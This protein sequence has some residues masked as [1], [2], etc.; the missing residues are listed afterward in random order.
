MRPAS[1]MPFLLSFALLGLGACSSLSGNTN[2]S[3]AGDFGW[4]VVAYDKS[5]GTDN[6]INYLPPQEYGQKLMTATTDRET[7]VELYKGPPLKFR[8]VEVTGVK[9][10]T[11]VTLQQ[12]GR[13]VGTVPFAEGTTFEIGGSYPPTA[14][15]LVDRSAWTGADPVV[16]YELLPGQGY[17]L[18]ELP[19]IIGGKYAG[20]ENLDCTPPGDI[21]RIMGNRSYTHIRMNAIVARDAGQRPPAPAQ[22]TPTKPAS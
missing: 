7:G 2:G 13:P 3:Q 11:Q 20:R 10:G 1:L 17:H 5:L 8:L 21:R 9:P 18:T 15:F 19:Y 22:A 4:L 12:S 16:C 14:F 6:V